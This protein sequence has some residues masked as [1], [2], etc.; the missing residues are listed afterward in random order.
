MGLQRVIS[1]KDTKLIKYS[2]DE[3]Q[4]QLRNKD[5]T[6]FVAAHKGD[7][8]LKAIIQFYPPVEKGGGSILWEHLN[9]NKFSKDHLERLSLALAVK[10]SV[11]EYFAGNFSVDT[12]YLVREAPSSTE[13][14]VL[15][16]RRSNLVH[17]IVH[18]IYY[19]Q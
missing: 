4:T 15:G 9:Q 3:K 14:D 10:I 2:N 7:S 5:V 6:V 19:E 1:K 17:I 8:Y 13:N 12:Q 11:F 18:T 16:E